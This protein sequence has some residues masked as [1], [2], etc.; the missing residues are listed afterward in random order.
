[1]HDA[2]ALKYDSVQVIAIIKDAGF[3]SSDLPEFTMNT[4]VICLVIV[5][6]FLSVAGKY[7]FEYR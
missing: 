5:I 4:S 7:E 1:M 3:S 2:R 6:A